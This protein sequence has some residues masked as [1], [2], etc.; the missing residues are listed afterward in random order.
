MTHKDLMAQLSQIAQ[1]HLNVRTGDA[2]VL[3]N[4]NYGEIKY[5]LVFFVT[6][7]IEFTPNQKTY[8][9]IMLVADIV[10]ERY[11]QQTL[12]VSNMLE[13]TKDIISYLINGKFDH[14]WIIDTSSIVST[15]FVDNLPDLCAGTQTTFRLKL[16]F[17]DSGCELPFSIDELPQ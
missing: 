11:L 5:P 1:A 17:D 9:I 16:P 2:G 10:D 6:D 15:P 4:L 12:I 3:E 7:F 13:I 8:N 14:P